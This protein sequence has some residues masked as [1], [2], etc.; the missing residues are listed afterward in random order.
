MTVE[1]SVE[2]A[3]RRPI[4]D[5]FAVLADVER[6][7][8]W[9]RASGIA[10][11]SRLDQGALGV[12][13]R[14]RIEQRLPGRASVLDGEVTVFDPPRGF[15]FAARSS[16][17]VAIEA[18]AELAADQG[19]PSDPPI[20]RLR[21]SIRLGLP[22]RFRLLEGMIAPEARAAATKDLGNLKR[23]LEVQGG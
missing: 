9:L 13:S 2:T 17:G 1:T 8:D 7:P 22:L 4:G 23:R 14:L 12:G 20:T 3:V 11:V 16:D 15:A 6:Y 19:P 5:V 10:A 18:L 21:W